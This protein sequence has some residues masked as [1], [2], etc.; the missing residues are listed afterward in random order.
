MDRPYVI[1]AQWNTD[2]TPLWIFI[3][4]SLSAVMLFAALV[5]VIVRRP[6]SF[7]RLRLSLRSGLGQRKVGG[8][9]I[10]SRASVVHCQKCGAGIPSSADCCYAC[11]AAQLRGQASAGSNSEKL[12]DRVYDYIV[13][14]HGEISLSQASK[15]FGLS[16]EE[17]KLSTERLKKKGR[18][19]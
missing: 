15:N 6:G 3:F 13:K 1:E 17:M 9:G 4:G 8:A 7:E 10:A 18:L 11:G 19:A 5:V 16:V 14:R 12:D 2:Y